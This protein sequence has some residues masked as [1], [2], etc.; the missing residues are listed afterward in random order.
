MQIVDIFSWVP[1]KVISLE[2]LMSIFSN[3]KKGMVSFEYTI[4]EDLPPNASQNITRGKEQLIKEGKRVAFIIKDSKI[5][6]LI[7]Y[8][9]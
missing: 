7:G 4:S 1:E 6:A 8:Q 3:Y 5:L 2:E 9:E